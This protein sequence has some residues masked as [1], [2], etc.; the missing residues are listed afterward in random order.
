[1]DNEPVE[2]PPVPA[3]RPAASHE[4]TPAPPTRG[5]IGAEDAVQMR[6]WLGGHLTGAKRPTASPTFCRIR[7]W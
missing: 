3:P 6:Q 1:M 4:D 2:E 5:D 7:R